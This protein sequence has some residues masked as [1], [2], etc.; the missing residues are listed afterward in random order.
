MKKFIQ[1]I[2]AIFKDKV[3][4]LPEKPNQ[5]FTYSLDTKTGVIRSEAGVI[6][7]QATNMRRASRHFKKLAEKKL[8]KKFTLTGNRP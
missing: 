6:Y 3:Q 1:K 4:A 8:G 2:K 5:A 7:V